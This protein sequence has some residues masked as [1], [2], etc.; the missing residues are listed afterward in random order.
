MRSAGGGGEDA[1]RGVDADE[2]VGVAERGAGGVRAHG[3]AGEGADGGPPEDRRGVA[4]DDGAED[5]AGALVIF[6]GE[7]G[8][9][10][11]LRD[12]VALEERLERAC[13]GGAVATPEGACEGEANAGVGL[14]G[15]GFAY[16]VD[17][18]LGVA[19]QAGERDA[20]L[21]AQRGLAGEE[22]AAQEG[23]RAHRS[24]GG[25]EGGEEPRGFDTGRARRDLEQRREGV[26][27]RVLVDLGERP[28]GGEADTR[29]GIAQALAETVH[30][31]GAGVA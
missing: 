17:G 18:G 23:A 5:R 28:G 27:G 19:G 30:R 6:A 10:L 20:G 1:A 25:L 9:R 22:R 3:V 7:E 15:E 16:G 14:L 12:S 4:R 24:L 8:G 29:L 31:G 26:A 11:D 2:R 21:G 13:G